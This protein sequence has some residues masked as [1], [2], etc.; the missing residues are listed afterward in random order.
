MA[1]FM[2]AHLD[3]NE[4]QLF[5]QKTPLDEMHDQTS[6]FTKNA[7][8]FW[9]R[10]GNNY[11]ILEHGGNSVGYTTQMTLLPEEN[12]GMVLLTNVGEEMSR[13][14]IYLTNTRLGE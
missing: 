3:S 13:L 7:H 2:L 14:R 4:Y 1:Y 8:G 10:S 12:F 5:E 6:R 9:E 11:R